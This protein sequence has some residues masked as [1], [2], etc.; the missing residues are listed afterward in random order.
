MSP[1]QNRGKSSLFSGF[2]PTSQKQRL[3]P[4]KG[5]SW[6]QGTIKY[7]LFLSC[8]VIPITNLSS[9]SAHKV[10]IAGDVG[11]TLHIEPNDNPR[12]GEP[13]QAWFALT[14]RGGRVIPLSQCNCRLAVYAQPYAAGEPP[15]LE[16]QLEP[17]AAERYQGIPG[18]EVV[19]PKP[20]IYQLQLNGKPLS[21]AR[22]K[23]FEFKFEVTVA[24]GSTQ[25]TRN[26]R[27]VNGDLVEGE[28][29]QLPI[30]AIA[31]PILGFIGIL[32]VV[33]RSMRGSG[34]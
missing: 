27:D 26:L 6:H 1:Q 32:V 21:G 24:G 5:I 10:E 31:L 28:S 20:G 18:A 19:F 13:S 34:E 16:P 25:N 9:A 12:A 3:Y 8:L 15:L 22:F 2:I 14:R 11:G 4:L 30:W 23:P 7:L 17:V 33:L 29:Q